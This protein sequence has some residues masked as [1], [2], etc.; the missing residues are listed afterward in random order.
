MTTIVALKTKYAVMEPNHGTQK[1]A[2]TMA[3]FVFLVDAVQVDPNLSCVMAIAVRL[4]WHVVTAA[5][6]VDAAQKT[7]IA[8]VLIALQ[9]IL[10][11]DYF[12]LCL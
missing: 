2:V 4:G 10:L 11:K 1:Y 5:A 7:I 6:G 3:M 8:T 12:L 9:T